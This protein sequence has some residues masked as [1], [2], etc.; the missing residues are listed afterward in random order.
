MLE[1]CATTDSV[2]VLSYANNSDTILKRPWWIKSEQEINESMRGLV[3]QPSD[4][5]STTWGHIKREF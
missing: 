3:V 4:K 1:T 5:L 2:R